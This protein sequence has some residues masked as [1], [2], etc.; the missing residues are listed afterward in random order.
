M[1][2]MMQ[3]ALAHLCVFFALE[4][5]AISALICLAPGAEVKWKRMT[6]VW[7]VSSLTE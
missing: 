5:E 3:R 1:I 4:H 6:G 2:I 7:N